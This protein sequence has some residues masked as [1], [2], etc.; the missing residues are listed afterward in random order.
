MREKTI[1]AGIIATA[2]FCIVC[3]NTADSE[4]DTMPAGMKLISGGT[5][6]MGEDSWYQTYGTVNTFGE[7]V[8]QV[9][10][11]AFHMDTTEVT[12]A[13][14]QALMGVNPSMQQEDARPVEM[15][16]WFDAALYCNARSRRD[17]RDTVYR[18]TGITGTAGAGSS[19]AG[20]AIDLTK[21]G[22][23]LPTEAEWEYACRSNTAT[24]WWW[25]NDTNGWGERS[26]SSN[27][28]GYTSHPVATR[29]ANTYGLYDM[30][31]NV[32]EWCN[33]W[34]E[35]YAA[36]EATDPAGA[37]TGTYRVFRGGAFDKPAGFDRSAYRIHSVPELRDNWKGFRCVCQ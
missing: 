22:Y 7:I 33:D 5:F 17:G 34:Y 25:G 21:N 8:R 13:D 3:G 35:S 31:G 12:Q 18:Y 28:S 29:L 16:T 19:L 10:L 14:Y 6:L 20:L 23:R 1:F 32:S 30:T 2:A 9:T 36:G 26:W 11:S 27:S 37:A 24:D 4:D 15:V